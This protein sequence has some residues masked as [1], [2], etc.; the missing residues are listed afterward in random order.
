MDITNKIDLL[1][2]EAGYGL[3]GKEKSKNWKT[4]RQ[5][6]LTAKDEKTVRKIMGNLE[7]MLRAGQITMAELQDLVDK[8]DQKILN[9]RK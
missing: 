1:L 6:I 8:A 5:S 9:L 7:K 4:L 2:N 3:Y